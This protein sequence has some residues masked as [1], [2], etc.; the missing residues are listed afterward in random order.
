VSEIF[1]GSRS[2]LPDGVFSNQKS[3]VRYILEGLAMEDVGK[4]NVHLVYFM[5]IRIIFCG[6]LVH[7]L[8]IWYIFPRF[9]MLYVPRKIWQPWSRPKKNWLKLFQRKLFSGRKKTVTATRR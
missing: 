7:F 5:D 1:S 2:G 8:V 4:F 9:G 6:H 3:K